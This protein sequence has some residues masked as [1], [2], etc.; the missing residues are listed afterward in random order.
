MPTTSNIEMM[1]PVAVVVADVD[2]EIREDTRARI[3]HYIEGSSARQ[4]VL[5]SPIESVE[6]SYF[7]G[8]SIIRDAGLDALEREILAIGANYIRWLGVQPPALEMERSWINIFHPKM[9]ETQH[10]HDGSILSCTYYV[11]AP[12]NCGDLIFQDPI[13]ARR[14]HRAFTN[15]SGPGMQSATEI[16]YAPKP[17]RLL[18]WES[19]LPHAVS[20]NKSNETRISLAFNLRIKR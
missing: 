11:L 14:S 9:Q 4:H 1:F 17:G 19:W 2:P 12:E 13:G 7:S 18:L 20:G 6:T 15:T 10:A 3:M 8:Q 5:P 16:N